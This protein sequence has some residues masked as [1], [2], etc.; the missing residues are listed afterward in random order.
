MC[1]EPVRLPRALVGV[2][3]RTVALTQTSCGSYSTVDLVERSKYSQLE[4][5]V[6][7]LRVRAYK[8]KHV[9]PQLAV[10]VGDEVDFTTATYLCEKRLTS[11]I[12]SHYIEVVAY[13]LRS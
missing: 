7:P 12:W 8:D 3:S 11:L 6:G 4:T 5:S 2:A 1:G 9:L 13:R 10:Q